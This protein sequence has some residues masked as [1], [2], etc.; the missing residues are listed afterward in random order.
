MVAATVTQ[1]IE[2]GLPGIEVVYLTYTDQYTYTSRKFKTIL[3]AVA[4]TN[5]DA[6]NDIQVSFA[7][8]VA[9]LQCA[10]AS[11]N[12]CTLILFGIIS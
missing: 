12:V 5:Q 1:Y 4:T 10:G 6:Q 7:T 8:N 2:T 11:G 9:T 3:G